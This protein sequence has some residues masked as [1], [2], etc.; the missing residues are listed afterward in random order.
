MEGRSLPAYNLIHKT[1]D[2]NIEFSLQELQAEKNAIIEKSSDAIFLIDSKG[3]ILEVNL[4]AAYLSGY[5]ILELEGMPAKDLFPDMVNSSI[6]GKSEDNRIL[7]ECIEKCTKIKHKIGS[8]LAID[9][10]A[11]KVY[12]QKREFLL[13]CVCPLS[14]VELIPSKQKKNQSPPRTKDKAT[15]LV[16]ESAY[17]FNHIIG[18]S[19]KIREICQLIGMVAK[20]DSTILIQGESGTGKELFAQTIHKAGH[21]AEEPFIPVN[22][23]A[24]SET[25]LESELFGHVKGAF[26]GAI[27]DR[28]GRFEEANKGTIL[29][30]EIGSMSMAGQAKLLR[31]LQECEFEPV[32]SSKTCRVDARVIATTNVD[33]MKAVRE[34]QFREDLY[35]RLN[36]FTIDLP[37]LRNRKEDILLLAQFFLNKYATKIHKT[38]KGFSPDTLAILLN[39]FWPGNVRELKNAIEHCVVVEPGEIIQPRSLPTRFKVDTNADKNK[40][41]HALYL[42]EK[43][44]II[45]RQIV[46]QALQQVNWVRKKAAKELGIDPRNLNYFLKKHN[47]TKPTHIFRH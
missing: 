4:K 18:R 47:I 22:C 9:L 10:R 33:L 40:D 44:A 2:Q 42:R 27:R 21:R 23:V 11:S 38:I 39:N 20:T 41:R 37:P 26:T 30:D 31:V 46:L 12:R 28:K 32:G 13:L 43:L 14:Q 7:S 36:V 1:S 16:R 15:V 34:D 24:L 8:L 29:L 5:T 35:Y 17:D 3:N 19:K 6:A 25:L 45:E